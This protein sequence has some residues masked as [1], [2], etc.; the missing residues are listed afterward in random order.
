MILPDLLFSFS[1][2]L[3]FSIFFSIIIRTRGER[4]GFLWF[5]LLI[6]LATWAGGI[7]ARPIGPTPWGVNWLGFV[8]I[9]LLVALLATINALRKPPDESFRQVEREQQLDRNQTMR[10]LE[11]LRHNKE[12]KRLNYITLNIFFWILLTT[13]LVTILIGYA[14]EP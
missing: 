9:G 14:I 3:A 8:V 10:M 13:L 4:A 1:V 12:A 11:E 5:F 2:A 7:W 6:F